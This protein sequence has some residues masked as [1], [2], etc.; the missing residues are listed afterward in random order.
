MVLDF[1]LSPPLILQRGEPD[2]FFGLLYLYASFFIKAYRLH[3]LIGAKS[4]PVRYDSN[5]L[6]KFDINMIQWRVILLFV[7]TWLQTA[8][9]QNH[10]GRRI[11]NSTSETLSCLF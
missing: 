8:S 2:F 6:K 11:Y 7:T 4:K 5:S 1:S 10:E 3:L 9:S